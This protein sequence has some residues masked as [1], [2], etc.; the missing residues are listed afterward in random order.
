MA[1]NNQN[2][3]SALIDIMREQGSF[4]NSP[5]LMIGEIL[6]PPPNI[7]I[8]VGD[9]QLDK[10]NLYIADYLLEDYKRKIQ[11]KEEGLISHS[12]GSVSGTTSSKTLSSVT[13]GDY[14]SH[15]HGSHNHNVNS[16]NV[17]N[18]DVDVRGYLVQK[19]CLLKRG[20]KVALQQING[21]NQFIVYARLVRLD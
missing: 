20:E 5:D 13:V 12:G 1:N 15:N 19:D 9:I 18:A 10:D 11:I 7:A 6:N 4:N 16:L 2:P 14:G 17:T 8:K 21:T 3:F